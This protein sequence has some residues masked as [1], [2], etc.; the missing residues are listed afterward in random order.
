MTVFEALMLAIAF[1]TLIVKISN[2]N[3]KK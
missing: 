3:D 2:K 1:A